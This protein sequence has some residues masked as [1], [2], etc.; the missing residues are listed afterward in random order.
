MEYGLGCR[1]L[2]WWCSRKWAVERFY[3]GEKTIFRIWRISLGLPAE[4]DPDGRTSALLS[5]VIWS[6]RFKKRLELYPVKDFMDSLRRSSARF[7]QSLAR[8]IDRAPAR[9]FNRYFTFEGLEHIERAQRRGQGI[10]L[11]T[12]HN[13]TNRFAIAALPRRIGGE[14]IPAL[15]M[16]FAKTLRT[17]DPEPGARK[18]PTAAILADAVV[19]AHRRLREGA[20]LQVIP[21]LGYDASDGMPLDIAGYRFLVKTG[22]AEL[23]L[24]SGAAV[25][26]QFSTRRRGGGIHLRFEQPFD[27]GGPGM[28]HDARISSLMEQYAVF[29]ECAWRKAPESLLWQVIDTHMQRPK[30]DS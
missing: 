26:P 9:R 12:Y 19:E 17:P 18:R 28:D 11:V 8:L 30:A 6:A 5:N 16:P 3:P 15:S 13:S 7:F 25:I 24:L 21:D 14:P 29:V 1:W 10:L 4:E 22:F 2:D 27:P 23:A 20:V